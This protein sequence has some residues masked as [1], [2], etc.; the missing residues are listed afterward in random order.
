MEAVQVPAGRQGRAFTDRQASEIRDLLRRADQETGLRFSVYV[1]AAEGD[2]RDYARRLHAALGTDSS[3]AVLIFID[4]GA[5]QLEI[6]TGADSC[7][8]LDD[9]T[10]A[11]AAMSMSTAFSVGDLTGGI[12]SGVSMLADHAR[13]P[14]IAHQHDQED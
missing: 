14:R 9:R 1:G 10:C 13:R 7:R 5:H 8:R 12:V 11:L 6:V 4:P 3:S 2:S